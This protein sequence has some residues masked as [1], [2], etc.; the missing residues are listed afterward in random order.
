M[1]GHLI[2]ISIEG[3][4]IG[5][6]ECE[7]PNKLVVAR[8]ARQ[9]KQNAWKKERLNAEK[10]EELRKKGFSGMSKHAITRHEHREARKKAAATNSAE[11]EATIAADYDAAI[12]D[13]AI[14]KSALE[15]MALVEPEHGTKEA[16]KDAEVKKK[17]KLADAKK[18]L[19]LKEQLLE[20]ER[21]DRPR[22]RATSTAM[23]ESIQ[24][25]I[26]IQGQE[27]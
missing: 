17:K 3:P 5:T 11:A 24:N 6:P 27:A 23:L 19:L 4:A 18:L 15:A 21:T 13:E 26:T 20:H 16:E 14:D 1:L 2:R 12:A 9:V 8:R 25:E 22:R 10:A 7:I